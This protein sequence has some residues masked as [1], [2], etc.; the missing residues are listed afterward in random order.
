MLRDKR[1]EY[2][3]WHGWL[4]WVSWGI[5]GVIMVG[6][7]RYLRHY[8]KAGVWIHSISGTIVFLINI[9]YGIGAMQQMEWNIQI[10]IHGIIGSFISVLLFLVTAT[11]LAARLTQ[12]R[13]VWKTNWILR[14]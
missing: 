12:N 6:S 10:S 8:W 5:F 11:G 9:V 13:L 7:M 3:K 14:I 2:L 1:I 4:M